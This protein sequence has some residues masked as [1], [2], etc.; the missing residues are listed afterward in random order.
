MILLAMRIANRLT[1]LMKPEFTTLQITELSDHILRVA[2][3][4]LEA[5]NAFNTQM[6]H[7]LTRVFEDIA[8]STAD[9]RVVIL[10]GCG[11]RAFCAGGDLKERNGMSD[12]QWQKQHVVFERMARAVINCPVPVIGAVNGAAYGGG[13]ELVASLDFVYAVEHAK[14]AQ[15]ETRLGIIPGIGGT[16]TLARAVG[17]RRA[18]ELILSGKVFS[19]KEAMEWGLVNALFGTVDEL[20]TAVF[21]I[22][23]RIASNAPLAV[24]QAKQSIHHGL[25]MSLF[26]GMAFEIQAY[27]R[28][29]STHDRLEGVSAFNEK[30]EPVFKGS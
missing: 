8:L 21:E 11:E 20:N 24:I 2:L 28:L 3:N 5:S 9:H 16:Q 18:K 10:T 22:A 27:N 14:F 26:D 30:R 6:A 7:E 17:E 25:Q 1:D 4:R 12:E 19:A 29:V 13:C 23:H 15:T